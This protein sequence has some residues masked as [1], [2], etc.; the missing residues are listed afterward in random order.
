MKRADFDKHLEKHFPGSCCHREESQYGW[1]DTIEIG[2]LVAEVAVVREVPRGSSRPLGVSVFIKVWSDT[3]GQC[4]IW[5][6][7]R[8]P[9]NIDSLAIVLNELKKNLLGM[10][11]AIDQVCGLTDENVKPVWKRPSPSGPA[12]PSMQD[13]DTLISPLPSD[14]P[15]EV[16][17]DIDSLISTLLK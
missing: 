3:K 14:E 6:F 7:H 8:A 1:I 12:R 11:A 5:S 15:E 9:C 13:I 2:Y 4:L 17:D 16:P 10:S